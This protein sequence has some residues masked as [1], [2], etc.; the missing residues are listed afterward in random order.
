MINIVIYVWEDI[1]QYKNLVVK[2]VASI[3]VHQ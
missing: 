3:L 2:Y 1:K